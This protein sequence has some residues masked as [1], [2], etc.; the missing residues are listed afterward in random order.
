MELE[1]N[2]YIQVKEISTS[3][4]ASL[5]KLKRIFWAKNVGRIKFETFGGEVWNLINYHV[6]Q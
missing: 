5:K 4:N 1:G 3:L 6:N 2:Q